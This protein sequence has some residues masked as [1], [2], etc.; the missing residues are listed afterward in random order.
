MVP[1]LTLRLRLTFQ[2]IV[3]F[4]HFVEVIYCHDLR[5]GLFFMLKT[6]MIHGMKK[7]IDGLPLRAIL[8]CL[9]KIS[10]LISSDV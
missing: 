3:C 10:L 2:D 9:H 5:K 4:I 7:L 1:E 8:F 6:L